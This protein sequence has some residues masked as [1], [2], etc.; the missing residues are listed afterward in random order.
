MVILMLDA[1]LS[2]PRVT[3]YPLANNNSNKRKQIS[4]ADSETLP[5][6]FKP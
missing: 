2:L 3:V 4:D 5:E 6:T 1:S